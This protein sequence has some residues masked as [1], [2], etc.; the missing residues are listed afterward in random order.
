MKSSKKIAFSGIFTAISLILLFL[1]GIFSIATYALPAMSGGLLTIAVI[2]MNKK[3]AFLIYVAVSVL[4]VVLT[5]DKEAAFLYIVFFG[6]YP[7]LKAVIEKLKITVFILLFK[8]L[9]LFAATALYLTA[10]IF[11]LGIKLQYFPVW[12][13]CIAA[14]AIIIVF[15]LYDAALSLFAAAYLNKIRPNYLSRLF[16]E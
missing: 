9:T 15:L 6:Y 3:Q 5:P 16:K 13:V 1:T 7:I 2:E 14:A 11:I 10:V 12:V 8:F 4:S